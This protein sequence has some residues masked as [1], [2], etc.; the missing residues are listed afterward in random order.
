[1]DLGALPGLRA[2]PPAPGHGPHEADRAPRP[3][4]A[5]AAHA[6]RPDPVREPARFRA[7]DAGERGRPARGR[8]ALHRHGRGGARRALG[9]LPQP[10]EPRRLAERDRRGRLRLG[11]RHGAGHARPSADRRTGEEVMSNPVKP[12]DIGM[13]RTGTAT[14]P[15]D[16]K[17]LAE[18]AQ[19]IPPAPEAGL[20]AIEAVRLEW[21]RLVTPVGTMPPPGSLKGAVKAAVT[22]LQGKHATPFLDLLG[23]RLA[24]ERTGTRLYDALLAKQAAAHP[25]PDRPSRDD[26]ESIRDDELRHCALL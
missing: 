8:H 10:A 17:K 21:S 12:T 1:G 20:Q 11:P 5:A 23:E 3:R 6:A 4:G 14:S 19:V 9:R 16:S 13:N 25:A 2:R 15:F 22:A 26:L 24:F 18:G 7:A